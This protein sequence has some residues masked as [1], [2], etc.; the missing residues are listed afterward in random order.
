M[1]PRGIEL[2]FEPSLLTKK[3]S[4]KKINVTVKPKD[5]SQNLKIE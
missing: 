3:I 2:N 4:L 5:L 1:I